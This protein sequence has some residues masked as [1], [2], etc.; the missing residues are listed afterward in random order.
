MKRSKGQHRRTI[1]GDFLCA[2]QRADDP[3][4]VFSKGQVV[5]AVRE[6]ISW[7]TKQQ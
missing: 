2:I 5:D 3:G 6:V 7:D 1:I 4:K